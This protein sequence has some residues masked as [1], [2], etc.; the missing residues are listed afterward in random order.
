MSVLHSV[1]GR[2]TFMFV[3]FFCFLH[4]LRS[5]GASLILT[6]LLLKVVKVKAIGRKRPA[7]E[8]M[9]A[10]GAVQVFRILIME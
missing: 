2:A 9:A 8:S 3:C 6:V 1:Y 5:F 4:L 7:E 10:E